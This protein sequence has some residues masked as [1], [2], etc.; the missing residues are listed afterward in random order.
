MKADDI[1]AVSGL[2]GLYKM[3]APRDNGMI[4]EDIDKGTTKFASVRKHQ[5]T[6]LGTVAIYTDSDSTELT[7]VFQRM[8]EQDRYCMD[9]L[10]QTTAVVAALRTVEDIVM[11]NHLN[12]CVADA[13][14]SNNTIEQQ[15]KIEEVMEVIGKLRKRG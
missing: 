10:T 2:P 15:E 12:T 5:F 9:I 6:P 3:V 8:V 1:V 7:E 13:M 14:R 4:I 11:Q